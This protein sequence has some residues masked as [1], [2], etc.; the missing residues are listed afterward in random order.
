MT[1]FISPSY[2]ISCFFVPSSS[3]VAVASSS[4]S[5]PSARSKNCYCKMRLA[6]SIFSLILNSWEEV[7]HAR[8]LKS[9]RLSSPASPA[10]GVALLSVCLNLECTYV[11]THLHFC[12][13]ENNERAYV[14]STLEMR[15][16]LESGRSRKNLKLRKHDRNAF[17][18]L[19]LFFFA[20]A[21]TCCHLV[22]FPLSSCIGIPHTEILSIYI[23]DGISSFEPLVIGGN[24][25][26]R[27]GI[28]SFQLSTKD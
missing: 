25:T 12:M 8:E 26:L 7:T 22:S 15:R 17:S 16:T 13:I 3:V 24:R 2:L 19:S 5:L 9:S 27:I 11:R 1:S 23:H 18:F 10:V 28:R 21:S 6:S 20:V 14:W 4:H